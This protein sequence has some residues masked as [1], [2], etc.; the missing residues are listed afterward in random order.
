MH[1]NFE[2]YLNVA[3]VVTGIGKGNRLGQIVMHFAP[4]EWYVYAGRPEF[5]NRLGVQVL[6]IARF[7]A[8]FV[9]GS[10]LPDLAPLPPEV[11]ELTGPIENERNNEFNNSNLTGGEGVAFGSSFRFD[12]GEKTFLIFY[13]RFAAIMGHDIML[14]NYGHTRCEG[15][16]RIGI[17]GWYAQGQAYAYFQ[18]T[19]GIDINIFF[20]RK[21]IPILSL[22][23]AVLAQAK[24]PNPVWFKGTVAGQFSVLGG[25][26]EGDFKM[27]ME[28]GEQCQVESSSF[29]EGL[30]VISQLSPDEGSEE[31]SVFTVPQVVF[32]YEVDK[33]FELEQVNSSGKELYKIQIEK[34]KMTSNGNPLEASWHLNE[35]HTVAV[36]K[37]KNILPPNSPV[38]CELEITFLENKDGT[39][40]KS[41]GADGITPVSQ[42]RSISF[43]TGA[44]PDHIPDH[45]I[46]L[47]YPSVNQMNYYANEYND[48]NI[49]LKHGQPYLFVD[50]E[51][52]S[53]IMKLYEGAN[54]VSNVS[55]TYRDRDN[56]L[57]FNLPQLNSEKIYTVDIVNEPKYKLTSIDENVSQQKFSTNIQDTLD[58]N[59][60]SSTAE[61]S[62]KNLEEKEIY[63]MSFRTSK[64]ATIKDK[65]ENLN[66]NPQ[67]YRH[68][69]I[70]ESGTPIP[71]IHF[72]GT[73]F[74]FDT[75]E[76][77]EVFSL[78]ER[79][80]DPE[81]FPTISMVSKLGGPTRAILDI[82]SLP[83]DYSSNF[84][85]NRTEF[86][87]PAPLDAIQFYHLPYEA[88]L[89]EEQ[90]QNGNSVTQPLIVGRI[91]NYVQYVLWQD[92]LDLLTQVVDYVASNN[93]NLSVP[94]NRKLRDFLGYNFPGISSYGF[95]ID[96]KYKIPRRPSGK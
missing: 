89:T 95:A 86:L 27:E 36:L 1:G 29:L 13:G 74:N 58:V 50:T 30:D 66:F 4:D 49:T 8:Y 88:S 28:F 18:G 11:S 64:Y 71:G 82:L 67:A 10:T 43:T 70:D 80:G 51:D 91:D 9:M 19:I 76:D 23:A 93:I 75:P 25:L 16:G 26:I 83:Q 41:T 56:S 22:K 79:I 2:A 92:Y 32:N 48:Q 5:E 63:A 14:A 81:I 60:T 40:R 61:G 96:F 31:I 45:N 21:K 57:V 69:V 7:D 24:L 47:S 37:S 94:A 35:K 77:N 55:F 85:L 78:S 3:N 72:I 12:T 44:A 46:L 68:P 52:F 39:W 62:L 53:Q 65:L 34:F 17:N 54:F 20:T 33:E 84:I 87:K 90:I 15:S 42:I 6:G 59:Q 73:M 38:L